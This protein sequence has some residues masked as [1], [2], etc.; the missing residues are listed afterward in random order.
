MVI[1]LAGLK[2]IPS[3]FYET[4][5]LAGASP[6]QKF[7]WVTWPLLKPTTLFVLVTNTIFTFQVF[8]PIY[9]MTGG[10]PVKSTIRR[11]VSPV[12]EGFRVP[13]DGVRLRRRVVHLHRAHGPDLL[14]DTAFEAGRRSAMRVATALKRTAYWL[15]MAGLGF[16]FLAPFVWMLLASLKT[17]AQLFAFP[18]RF[19][20]DP[21]Q[22]EQLPQGVD[23]CPLRPV[24]PEQPFR[25]GRRDRGSQVITS[26]MAAYVFARLRFPFRN[27]LFLIYL[28][29]MMIPS[30]VTVI[31]LFIIV[32]KLGLIDT[33]AALILPFLA[34]PFGAFMMR[35][36]FL[37]IPVDY[38]D[39]ARVDGC[40]R[41]GILFRVLVPMARPALLT[42][43]MLSFMWTWNDF[44]WPLIST[45]TTD[46]YTI[47][48]GLA[49]LK[50]QLAMER[51]L[52]HPH[53]PRR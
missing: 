53:G 2:A 15:V 46:H 30:Q 36:F 18:P 19:F 45:N 13:G 39:A 6:W 7:R 37:T 49:M 51:Q 47:Q 5:T 4:A 52:E 24:L 16:V 50:S 26:V 23:Q 42:L 40:R 33:Y 29:V 43:A 28:G 1:F 9:V 31:P 12:P 8:G 41:F 3:D 22:V 17:N 20:P 34:Y 25:H 11:R 27:G 10:G 38:E 14:P 21:P 32:K 35:Q 44:F 48:V